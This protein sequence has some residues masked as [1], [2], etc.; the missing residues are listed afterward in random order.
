M[1]R[2]ALFIAFAFLASAKSASLFKE[3]DIVG[4]TVV[5]SD[6]EY[7]FLAAIRDLFDFFICGG[8]IINERYVL[9]AAHCVYQENQVSVSVG[10]RFLAIGNKYNIILI[11]IHPNFDSSNF[12]N[13]VSVLLTERNFIFSS[14]VA[15]VALVSR[16]I[17]SGTAATAVGWGR[18]SNTSP[19]SEV[20]QYVDLSVSSRT[21]CST[22]LP[23]FNSDNIC[24]SGST[25]RG[26]CYGDLGGPLVV[27]GEGVIG[28]AAFFN[29]QCTLGTPD[30][31][32]GITYHRDWIV[33]NS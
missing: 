28:I 10:S 2:L 16:T 19:V 20:L 27:K 17:S 8:T 31:Y 32:A 30:V 18:T 11:K 4:G 29:F 24:T 12:A 1:T 22:L 33:E 23:V 9:T 26:I 21:L 15:P 7:P 3:T 14:M 13:D 5:N 25:S 6:S